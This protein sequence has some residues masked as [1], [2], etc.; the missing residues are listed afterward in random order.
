M[1]PLFNH[2]GKYEFFTDP[3]PHLVIRD[4]LDAQICDRLVAEF[5]AMGIIAQGASIASNERFSYPAYQSLDDPN[6]SETWK[7]FVRE[8]TSGQFLKE[9]TTRFRDQIH[10]YHPQFEQTV[11]PIDALRPGM[12]KR[13]DFLIADV[14]MDAQICINAPVTADPEPIKAPHIDRPQ[15]LFAGLFYLRHADDD[16]TGGDLE[17]FRFK[18]SKPHSFE[19]QF[20][21][22]QH[23]ERVRTVK[24]ERNAFVLFLNSPYSVHGVTTRSRTNA[25]RCFANLI[26]EVKQPLFDLQQYQKRTNLVQRFARKVFSA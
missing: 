17:I 15:V 5:P 23:V 18:K 20:V 7:A 26:G 19:H 10:H 12:R 13:D 4:A 21:D 16:A 9:V 24:Y 1:Q 2:S 25:T 11:A 14:L 3:F 6:I 8:H 22:Y